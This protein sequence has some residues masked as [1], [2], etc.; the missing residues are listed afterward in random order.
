MDVYSL[1]P[2]VF[3]TGTFLYDHIYVEGDCHELID[4]APNCNFDSI[5]D[6]LHCTIFPRNLFHSIF[7][8]K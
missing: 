1:Y 8:I 3:K 2:Y 5:K 4:A 6:F 7:H